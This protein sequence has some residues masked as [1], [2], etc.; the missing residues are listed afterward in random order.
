MKINGI[1]SSQILTNILANLYR[2]LAD[3]SANIAFPI[4]VIDSPDVAK[5]IFLA[6]TLFV[7]N[8]T[9]IENL[10][11]GR[12]SANGEDW[13]RRA[14]ITQ[15]FFSQ[16]H[17][18]L[19]E[20][21]IEAV[22]K[23]HLLVYL[24][25]QTPNLYET[26][27]NAALDVVSQVLG[28]Q[29]PIPWPTAL[30][31][32]AREALIDQQAM[33]WVTADATLMQQ[34]Q[35]ELNI[36]FTEFQ[37]L[38][39]KNADLI[40]LLTTF[41]VS[42]KSIPNFNPVGE[43]LQILFASTETTASSILWI[44]ECLT[45]HC[46]IQAQTSDDELECFIDEVLRLFPPVPF[47]TRVCLEDS[48]INGIHFA[49]DEPIIISI[50]G[51]HCHPQYWS[52]PLLFKARREEFVSGHYARHAYIPFLSGPRACAG[53]KLANQEIKCGIRALLRI[54]DIK[55]CHEERVIE[56]GISSRPGIKLESYLV[57]HG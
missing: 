3:P 52:E 43:L 32:R 20:A 9:F 44:I 11:K 35:L 34:S 57:P 22:Y 31:N 18:V 37:T 1:E 40:N 42:G 21:A 47:V 26:I 36:I 8:Y 17:I 15:S 19:D 48:E 28:L 16:A 50:I 46:K 23:K 56:Y 33:S 24:N 53:M 2:K 12:F 41:A 51:V 10:S 29:H 7:K 6:P 45:R 14:S 5:A 55:P 27:I 30:A 49:K 54:F 38:W 13:K 4:K 25:S 39:E